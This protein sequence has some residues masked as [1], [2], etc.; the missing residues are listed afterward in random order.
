MFPT[1]YP[2]FRFEF[3]KLS[4]PP[5]DNSAKLSTVST[6]C[7][8]H[9]FQQKSGPLYLAVLGTTDPHIWIGDLIVKKFSTGYQQAK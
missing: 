6:G 4:T 1:H 2:T 3:S 9:E 5:V 8:V 7:F